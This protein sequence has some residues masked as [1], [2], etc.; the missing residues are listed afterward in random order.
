ML[1]RT[2][3]TEA[4][5]NLLS[6]AA[7]SPMNG[8]FL[9]VGVNDLTLINETYG[10]DVGDELIAIV[11]RRLGRVVRGKDCLGRFSSN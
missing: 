6:D 9:L 10:Y 8:A 4:L 5:S 2:Q 1:N 3:L 7:R 11:G